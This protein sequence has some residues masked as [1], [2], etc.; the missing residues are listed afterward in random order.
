MEGP[1]ICKKSLLTYYMEENYP[2][3]VKKCTRELRRL[4]DDENEERLSLLINRASS[5]LQ[6]GMY[7]HCI[8]DCL[9]AGQIDANWLRPHF[10]TISALV[11]RGRKLEAQEVFNLWKKHVGLGD[12]SLMK[13]IHEI[14]QKADDLAVYD[15]NSKEES[16]SESS[17]SSEAETTTASA[18]TS[19]NKQN[20][21]NETADSSSTTETKE[22]HQQKKQEL[23]E[24]EEMD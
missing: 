12:L 11:A 1:T 3:V 6:L 19:E 20:K 18:V 16:S 24:P 5:Y 9:A 14:L 13:Q 15:M 4:P 21:Q 23:M 2:R 8:Q 10:L 7:K 22:Q 17:E